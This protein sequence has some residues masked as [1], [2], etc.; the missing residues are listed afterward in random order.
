VLRH[1][2]PGQAGEH[3]GPGQ[4]GEQA[5]RQRGHGA[6]AAS[7]QPSDFVGIS[8]LILCSVLFFQVASLVLV[9]VDAN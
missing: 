7:G 3:T 2:G 1:T 8:S 5:R 9:A 4:A 6:R